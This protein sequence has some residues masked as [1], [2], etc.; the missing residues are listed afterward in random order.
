MLSEPASQLD[1]A[2]M[3]SY[4][5]RVICIGAARDAKDLSYL[6]DCKTSS[7]EVDEAHLL[8]VLP[9]LRNSLTTAGEHGLKVII[10]LVDLPGIP[11]LSLED[12]APM[13]FG[14]NQGLRSHAAKFWGVLIKKSCGPKATDNG[15]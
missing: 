14:E 8:K 13:P 1:F 11:F 7:A 12:E 9:R 15:L 2:A 3:A 10:T 4:G 5:V 6:L